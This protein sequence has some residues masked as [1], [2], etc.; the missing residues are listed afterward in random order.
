MI[1]LKKAMRTVVFTGDPAHFITVYG[2]GLNFPLTEKKQTSNIHMQTFSV[3]CLM[4]KKTKNKKGKN[5]LN[6]LLFKKKGAL[7]VLYDCTI[8]WMGK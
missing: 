8:S 5:N 6:A 2:T 4:G 1:V 7:D 3:P